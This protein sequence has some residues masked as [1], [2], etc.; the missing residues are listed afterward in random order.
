M[1]LYKVITA[2][3]V[4]S[5]DREREFIRIFLP[6]AKILYFTTL[7]KWYQSVIFERI[8]PCDME[9]YLHCLEEITLEDASNPLKQVMKHNTSNKLIKWK[10]K[11]IG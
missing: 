7:I 2:F 4:L 8:D 11:R 1:K 9:D 3:S 5:S 6:G 10:T